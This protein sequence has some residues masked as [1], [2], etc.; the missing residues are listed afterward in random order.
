MRLPTALLESD[1]F[2]L[3]RVRTRLIRRL[4]E[5]HLRIGLRIGQGAI[6][7]CLDEGGPLTQ[8]DLGQLLEVD[9][10]E[11][12]RNLDPLEHAGFVQRQPDPLDRRRNIL[13]VT[14]DGRAMRQT[15]DM[16]LVAV[17]EEIFGVVPP[18]D[19]PVLRRLLCRL[20]T[21]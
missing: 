9:P 21:A 18:D 14:G 11:L 19:R 5:E 20:A 2:L 8:R 17:Q 16:M 1:V 4:T 3:G 12:V 10:S 13:D 7:I 6:L 15:Y